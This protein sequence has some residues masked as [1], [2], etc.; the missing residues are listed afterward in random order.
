MVRFSSP[1]ILDKGIKIENQLPNVAI[2]DIQVNN[3]KAKE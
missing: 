1:L 2:L 3:K